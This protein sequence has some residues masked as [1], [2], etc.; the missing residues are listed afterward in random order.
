[1]IDLYGQTVAEMQ[2]EN[3][4]RLRDTK[5]SLEQLRPDT[6]LAEEHKRLLNLYER[7]AVA[8]A[9]PVAS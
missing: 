6:W 9:A 7:I 5:Q 4:M 3:S 2:R 1:M 8:L